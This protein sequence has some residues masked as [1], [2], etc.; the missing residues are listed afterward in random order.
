MTKHKTRNKGEQH[1][2][3][4]NILAHKKGKGVILKTHFHRLYGGV[5]NMSSRYILYVY[6]TE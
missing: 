5:C 3:G 2:L 1:E 4:K 6:K